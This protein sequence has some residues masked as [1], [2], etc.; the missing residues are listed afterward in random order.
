MKLKIKF[1]NLKM[2]RTNNIKTNIIMKRTFLLFGLI[3]LPLISF[4]QGA[5]DVFEDAKDVTSVVVTKNMLKLLSKMDLNSKDPEAQAYLNMVENLDNIKVFTTENPSVGKKMDDAVAKYLSSSSK[6]EELMRVNDSGQTIKFYVKE[7]KSEN[8]VNELLM[9]L[10]GNIN[11]KG[12]T[13]IMSI[14]GDLDLREISKLTADL[15]IPGNE[16][17][18]N[19]DKKKN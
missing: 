1:S 14:T 3:L 17:L 8:H 13:V 16:Q 15:K 19:I 2:N 4:G 10:T 9:H 18:K 11:G 7:G 6:L 12:T 5:F